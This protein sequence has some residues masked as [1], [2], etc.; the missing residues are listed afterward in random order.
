MRNIMSVILLAASCLA[1]FGQEV[2]TFVAG[3]LEQYPQAR[4]LDV[5]KSCFQDYMGAE[6]LIGDTASVKA[7]LMQELA[8]T[9]VD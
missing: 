2:E 7:Y 4:L 3:L 5:Y 8:T 6:H 9:G 1:G